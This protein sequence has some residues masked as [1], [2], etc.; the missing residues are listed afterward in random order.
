MKL[1]FMK[2]P[3]APLSSKACVVCTAPISSV[4]ID[5]LSSNEF[6]LMVE[7]TMYQLG[8]CFSHRGHFRNC[9][10]GGG[11]VSMTCELSVV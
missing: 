7:A 5:T 11:G 3:I 10:E 2:R 1:E 9:E 4:C 8:S 6:E